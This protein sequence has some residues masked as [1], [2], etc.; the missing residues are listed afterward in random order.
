MWFDMLLAAYGI[1]LLFY[2]G[3]S[4]PALFI[5]R[6]SDF[7]DT[8]RA[9]WALTIVAVP[10]MGAIAFATIALRPTSR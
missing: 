7:D 9:I 2:L 5:L 3:F 10:V 6:R 4:L 8:T 1:P